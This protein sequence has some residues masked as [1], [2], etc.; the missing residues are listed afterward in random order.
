MSILLLLKGKALKRK[1]IHTMAFSKKLLICTVAILA[2]ALLA[3]IFP[4]HG[5]EAIYKTV[6]RLH[7]VANSDS[8]E[9]Q[10]L[11]L[12]V[13]DSIIEIVTPAVE[14][15]KTQAEAVCAIEQILNELEEAAQATVNENG[16][17][18]PV[19]VELGNE[20]YPTKKYESCAFPEGEYVSLRVLIGEH[21]GQN[22]WCC[23]F[24]PLCLSAAT[25]EGEQSNEDAF[26]SVGLTSDQYKLVTET[27]NPKYR[28][29]FKIL[30]TISSWFK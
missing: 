10:A 1:D 16:Y 23:L 15:C 21:A 6:V 19:A 17:S 5:E 26:I 12:K 22:W 28:V 24:P 20:Y 14:G 29:R 13:R 30:E 2:V 11:K 27:E 7:V 3:G 8:A 4:V 9:D 18:Y 25:P